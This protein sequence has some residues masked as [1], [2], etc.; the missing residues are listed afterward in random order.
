MEAGEAGVGFEAGG[1][2]AF[3]VRVE[4][5]HFG[6]GLNFWGREPAEPA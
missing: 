4:V 2:E 5:S 1:E 3:V 6:A